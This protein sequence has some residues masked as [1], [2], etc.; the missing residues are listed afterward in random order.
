MKKS[1][2][3]I[4]IVLAGFVWVCWAAENALAWVESIDILAR[5]EPDECYAGLGV[6]Y[7]NGPSCPWGSKEKRNQG[8]VWGLTQAGDSLWFGT[9]ANVFC[10]TLGL[11]MS[12]FFEM[13]T[14]RRVCEYGSGYFAQKHPMLPD[15]VGDWRAPEIFEYDL[16]TGQLIDR[17]PYND[18]LLYRCVGLRS[19]GS[20]DGV[21]FL[22]GGSFSGTVVMFAFD[23]VTKE[24]LGSHQFSE[25]RSIRKWL[26]LN[27]RL[28][29]GMGVSSRGCIVRWFGSRDDLWDFRVVGLV[30]GLPRELAEYVDADG[31]KRMVVSSKGVWVSPAIAPTTVGLLPAQ[32]SGW[33][34]VWNASFYEPDIVTRSTYVGGGIFFFDGWVY[35]GTMHIPGNAADNHTTCT[36]SYCFGEPHGIIELAIL[37]AGTWRATSIWRVRN[38]ESETPE[39]Q[40]LYGEAV[41]PAFDPVTRTF[42]YVPNSGGYMPLYGSSG[43]GNTYNNY[44]WVMT[45]ANG[46]LFVGTMDASVLFRSIFT[47]W[48][49]DLWRFDNSNSPAQLES[50]DGLGNGDNYGIRCLIASPDGNRLYVG[51]ANPM[52]LDPEGGWSLLQLNLANTIQSTFCRDVDNDGF[53]TDT[54]SVQSFPHR[55]DM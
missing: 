22:A 45:G 21:V 8:Y 50:D 40:L 17:T 55:Q 4:V 19:A 18:M 26:V 54:D 36:H 3:Q 30:N 39:I 41:L 44:S 28:Y 33:T 47:T 7:P 16:S 25:Y 23:A 29:A 53:G 2:F 9:G 34:E 46:H 14:D 37:N 52:N 12:E 1:C 13:E 38:L 6:P 31:N 48:G 43:F 27:N 49:A 42:P 11:F 51:T 20:H 10:T 15:R 32:A 35:F 5:A 24:Y